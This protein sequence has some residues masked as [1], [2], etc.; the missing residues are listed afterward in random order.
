VLLSSSQG[1][2]VRLTLLA[3]VKVLNLSS[4]HEL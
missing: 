4:L 2:S 1:W 3:K